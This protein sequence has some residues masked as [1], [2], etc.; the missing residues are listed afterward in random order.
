MENE[1]YS[2]GLDTRKDSQGER[3]EVDDE[4]VGFEL[5][6]VAPETVPRGTLLLCHGTDGGYA[7]GSC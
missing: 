7:E 1:I 5:A 3:A 4:K 6:G 2:I